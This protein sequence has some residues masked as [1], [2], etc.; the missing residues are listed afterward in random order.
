MRT[1]LILVFWL[2]AFAGKSQ[3]L[4][5]ILLADTADA[6]IRPAVKVN[7]ERM[8]K[9]LGGIAESLDVPLKVSKVVTGSP[10]LEEAEDLVRGVDCGTDD[11]VIFHY[12]G[13]GVSSGFSHWPRFLIDD[14]EKKAG[15]M[16]FNAILKQKN[17]RLLISMADCCNIGPRFIPKSPRRQE[18]FQISAAGEEL[19]QLFLESE[20]NLICSSSKSGEY[21]YYE[22]DLGGYYTAAF[23]WSLFKVSQGKRMTWDDLMTEVN[24]VTS[25]MTLEVNRRQNPQFAWLSS[26]A[27]STASFAMAQTRVYE[28]KKGDTLWKIAQDN[29]VSVE[30]LKSWNSL[31]SSIIRPGQP[32]LIWTQS[33]SE[34]GSTGSTEVRRPKSEKS[35]CEG[36][37]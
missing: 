5:L 30:N 25:K 24:E 37:I 13:H 23:C 16:Y 20:G 12:S 22:D 26:E 3:V 11:I 10:S 17:P 33:T 32:L 35:S 31:T 34:N 4:H 2:G 8:Q 7:V 14:P 15:L 1:V 18:R 27:S 28:V 36:D 29:Q 6:A 19:K 9:Q 21:A